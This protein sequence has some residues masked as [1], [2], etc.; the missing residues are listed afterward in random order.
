MTNTKLSIEE[1]GLYAEDLLLEIQSDINKLTEYTTFDAVD[2]LD[3]I[4]QKLDLARGYGLNVELLDNQILDFR[5]ILFGND[6]D[7]MM[8]KIQNE[9][10]KYEFDTSRIDN[11]YTDLLAEKKVNHAE[12]IHKMKVLRGE[13]LKSKIKFMIRNLSEGELNSGF[14]FDRIA[15]EVEKA[16]EM[17]LDMTDIEQMIYE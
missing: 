6:Y 11:E 5:L 7:Y 3:E 14:T 9:Q 16:K 4:N 8:E 13:V 10:D 12:L 15:I 1:I 17:G 2:K